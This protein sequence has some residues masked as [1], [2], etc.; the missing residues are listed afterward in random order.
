M[1]KNLQFTVNLS[2]P[3]QQ[4]GADFYIRAVIEVESF[5]T[6]ETG[7]GYLADP[8]GYDAGSGPEWF[9]AEDPELFLDCGGDGEQQGVRAELASVLVDFITSDATMIEQVESAIADTRKDDRKT[10]RRS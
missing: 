3:G 1:S 5:G 7:S 10:R 8:E 6:A 9:V 2:V 4:F